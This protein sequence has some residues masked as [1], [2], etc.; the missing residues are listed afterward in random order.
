MSCGI[1]LSTLLLIPCGHLICTECMECMTSEVKSC[2]LCGL[3][4]DVDDFQRLQP[5]HDYQWYDYYK[6]EE[7]LK[8][9][10]H[11]S[12]ER[13]EREEPLA[14]QVALQPAQVSRRV[15]RL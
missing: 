11:S 13:G 14:E 15:N 10:V 7:K 3:D 2:I 8:H 1:E 6:Q 12:P 4:F 5:G 9:G